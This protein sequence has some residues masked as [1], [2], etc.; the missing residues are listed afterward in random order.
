MM[1]G[2]R[3]DRYDA[4]SKERRSKI[5]IAAERE[6]ESEQRPT[7]LGRG[8]KG[9]DRKDKLTEKIIRWEREER[10]LVISRG[11]WGPANLPGLPPG[12][13]RLSSPR[14][15]NHT[16]QYRHLRHKVNVYA[17]LYLISSFFVS[18]TLLNPAVQLRSVNWLTQASVVVLNF[19]RGNQ[20]RFCLNIATPRRPMDPRSIYL[21]PG[22]N[23]TKVRIPFH[24]SQSKEK[25]SARLPPPSLCNSG[26]LS[27][28]S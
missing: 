28:L 26:P 4:G 2:G 10:E 8:G 25:S 16:C 18:S 20:H 21:R 5:Q 19:E 7:S 23:L 24:G 17:T 22:V 14:P 3:K 11:R 1:G 15:P 12:R 6:R 13:L 27:L 9:E